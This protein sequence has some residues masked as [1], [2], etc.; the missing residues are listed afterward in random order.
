MEPSQVQ[1]PMEYSRNL[2]LQVRWKIN[3]IKKQYNN[4]KAL[5]VIDYAKCYF[6]GFLNNVLKYNL[7]IKFTCFKCTIQPFLAHLQNCM[8]TNK[9][10]LE[11]LHHPKEILYVHVHL[12][13]Q[14]T[15]SIIPI[16]LYWPLLHRPFKL[17]QNTSE[18]FHLA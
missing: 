4:Q 1:G 5:T 14:A 17:N 16:S 6:Q 3:S 9:L 13:S 12:Q 18:S 10:L 7:N 11:N 2:S 15:N 8:I